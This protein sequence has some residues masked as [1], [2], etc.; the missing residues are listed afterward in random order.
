[1]T[2]DEMAARGAALVALF[3][4]A[5]KLPAPR[6]HGMVPVRGACGL[7]RARGHHI[8]VD[9]ARCAR[10]GW[11]GPAW[12]WPGYIIDRTPYGVHAHEMGHHIDHVMG[13][14]ALVAR[15]AAGE[16]RLTNYCPNN[17]EWFAEMCRLFA[18][19]PALLAAVRPATYNHLTGR[20]GLKPVEQRPWPVVLA[21]APART[22]AMAARRISEAG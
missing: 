15:L 13:G 11:G 8:H 2:R 1:M 12:S 5:N 3:C 7:Y 6:L 22:L 17:G 9:T 16:D 4:R 18:T 20:L 10:L 14:V 19:N 21:G